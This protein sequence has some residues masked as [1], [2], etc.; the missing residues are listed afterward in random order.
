M[1]YKQMEKARNK[2][3]NFLADLA[4]K[5]DKLEE[6]IENK[7]QRYSENRETYLEHSLEKKRS[8]R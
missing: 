6:K 1:S 5:C 4:L 2:R 7:N 3:F 8:L